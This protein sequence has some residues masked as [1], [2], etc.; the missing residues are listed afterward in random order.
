ML[1][2]PIINQPQSAI[3]GIHATKDRPVAEYGQV[4]IRSMNYLAL[5]HDQRIIGGCEAVQFLGAIKESLEYPS[6]QFVPRE[7]A[8]P[9]LRG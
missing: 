4:V 6:L 2:T 3:L 1:S 5:S 8:L 9:A 7:E